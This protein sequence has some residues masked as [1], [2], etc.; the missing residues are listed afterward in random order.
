MSF[1]SRRT[2]IVSMLV[3]LAALALSVVPALAGTI[4][5]GTITLTVRQNNASAVPSTTKVGNTLY[6]SGKSTGYNNVQ[7]IVAAAEIG[8]AHV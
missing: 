5:S 7:V 6:V 1:S 8:R 3:V 4:T 2:M